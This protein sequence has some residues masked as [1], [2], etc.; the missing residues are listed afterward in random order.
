MFSSDDEPAIWHGS[1]PSAGFM[2]IQDRFRP[3][4]WNRLETQP[5]WMPLLERLDEKLGVLDPNYELIEVRSVDGILRF[6]ATCSPDDV[7]FTDT[8]WEAMLEA[9]RTC[10]VCAAPG[11]RIRTL[12]ERAS[13][14]CEVHARPRDAIE[15]SFL[16]R[17]GVPLPTSAAAVPVSDIVTHTE[18]SAVFDRAVTMTHLTAEELSER[19]GVAPVEVLRLFG[20]GDLAG[21]PGADRTVRFPRWQLTDSDALLPGLRRVLAAALDEWSPHELRLAMLRPSEDLDGLCPRQWMAGERSVETIAASFA[22]A[23]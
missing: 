22:H 10:E 21:A 5:G 19:I 15:R 1:G 4:Y 17:A 8:I 16:K 13:V 20:A 12:D 3:G 14:C 2:R 23:E 18:I 7:M 6:F 9:S 11:K